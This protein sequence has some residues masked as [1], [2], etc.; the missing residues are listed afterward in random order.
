MSDAG[1]HA[2]MCAEGPA[3]WVTG[4][5]LTDCSLHGGEGEGW[6]GGLANPPSPP[7]SSSSHPPSGVTTVSRSPLMEGGAPVWLPRAPDSSWRAHTCSHS[8]TCTCSA[9]TH[10]HAHT[11]AHTHMHARPCG[12]IHAQ[13]HRRTH[14]ETN[15]L[16]H[17]HTQAHVHR[18]MNK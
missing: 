7:S 16:I 17:T 18:H 5:C 1:T 8:H 2:G 10:T 13:K 9:F 11:H 12:H 3:V 4:G 6:K 14:T 15:L